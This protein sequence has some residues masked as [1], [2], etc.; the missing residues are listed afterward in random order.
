M[1]HENGNHSLQWYLSS[2][3]VA[4]LLDIPKGFYSNLLA[5]LLQV[6]YCN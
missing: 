2:I 5:T 1:E 4:T 3:G 6:S